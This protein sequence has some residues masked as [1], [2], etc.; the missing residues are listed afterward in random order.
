MCKTQSR[1]HRLIVLAGGTDMASSP[2]S[3]EDQDALAASVQA[4]RD[5]G[6]CS[7]WLGDSDS[8][9]YMDRIGNRAIKF[10]GAITIV[11]CLGILAW[12]R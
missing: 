3:T 9:M 10:A 5:T 8:T 4:S 7:P 1:P 2:H 12:V 11:A 6:C